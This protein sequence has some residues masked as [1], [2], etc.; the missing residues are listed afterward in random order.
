MKKGDWVVNGIDMHQP[1]F[2]TVRDIYEQG[3]NT[4]VDVVYYSYNGNRLGRISPAMGGPRSYEPAL[5]FFDL[6]VIERPVFPM[7]CSLSGDY[8]KEFVRKEP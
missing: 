7:R 5:N 1:N 6:T 4:Y 2:G 3:G 8:G